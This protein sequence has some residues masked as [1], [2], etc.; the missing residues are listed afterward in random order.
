MH[1]GTIYIEMVQASRIP[2]KPR[3]YHNNYA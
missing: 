1:Q 2:G 3:E